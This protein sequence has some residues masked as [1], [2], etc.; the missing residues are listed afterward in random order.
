MRRTLRED[1]AGRPVLDLRH[2]A[3]ER[4]VDLSELP[5]LTDAERALAMRT[6][7]GRMVNEHISAQVWG[8]LLGQLM[9]AAVPPEALRG[10]AEAASD[11]LR[12]A[13][14]C[15]AVVEALG[16]TAVAPL[17]ELEAVPEHPDATPLEAALRNL[18][19]VGCMSETIA[20]SIIR[21]EQAELDDSVLGQVLS[22]IL[23]DEV[24][25]ARL[26]WGILGRCAPALDAELKAR[27]SAYL[28]PAFAHQIAHE[29]PK[30]P[31]LDGGAGAAAQAGVCDGGLAR[32]IF[33]DTMEQVI[34][35]GLEKAGLDA[36][37]AWAAAQR[38][39]DPALVPARAS[40]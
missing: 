24:A 10:V 28:V 21:A 12:H 18:I 2:A 26:G 23:A 30:L 8:A 39:V 22:T 20:V 38:Q 40:A 27:L 4:A 35:P 16:G 3:R 37:T 14:Q 31:V 15:A 6:W 29:I 33:F 5:P 34:V 1:R 32:K 7:R 11:E 13:E 9:R 36:R 17:P 19:S 25:H